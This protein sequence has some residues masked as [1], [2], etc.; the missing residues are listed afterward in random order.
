MASG[1]VGGQLGEDNDGDE[2][3]NDKG[4]GVGGGQVLSVVDSSGGKEETR[5]GK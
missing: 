1:V 2:S 4:S 5:K 3:T